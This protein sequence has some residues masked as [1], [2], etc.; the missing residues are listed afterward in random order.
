MKIGININCYNGLPLD[1]QIR[2][3]K[4][5]GFS[6]CFLMGRGDNFDEIASKIQ[7]AGITIDNLHAPF[8]G[9]NAMWNEGEDGDA[10]LERLKECVSMAK[11]HGIPLIVVH[12]SSGKKPPMINDIGNARFA[13]L[14]AFA[15]EQGVKIAYENQRVLSN[16]AL[17]LEHYDDAV[18]CWDIGHETC[19]ANGR[20]YM[21]LFGN[22][23][24]ALHVQDNTC[25]ADKD[26]H[27]IPYDG[28][29]DLDKAARYIAKTGFDGCVMLELIKVKCE[30]YD[31]I[32]AEEYYERAAAAARRFA[33]AIDSYR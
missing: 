30:M 28:T 10:M 12:L 20:E 22:R 21:P 23:L 5:N 1:E 25:E 18:F 8:D 13:E 4:K 6:S 9:I 17:M 16:L 2:L 31:N 14:M 19:F 15:R 3:I 27:L 33:D 32:S 11:R 7:D 24:A 26:L 29:I